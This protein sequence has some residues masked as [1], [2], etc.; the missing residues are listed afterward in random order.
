MNDYPE[1]NIT[2]TSVKVT[3]EIHPLRTIRDVRYRG[4]TGKIKTMWNWIRHHSNDYTF[5]EYLEKPVKYT[6]TAV[7]AKD[8]SAYHHIDAEAELIKM[9]QEEEE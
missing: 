4:F 8:I 9:L 3:A 5:N 7:P 6:L 2:T 1:I